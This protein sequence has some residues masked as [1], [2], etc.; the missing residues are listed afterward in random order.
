M[1]F[2]NKENA[3]NFLGGLIDAD[4]SPSLHHTCAI[5]TK[6]WWLAQDLTVLFMYLNINYGIE[7]TYNKTYDRYYYRLHIYASSLKELFYKDVIRCP[8]K[9]DILEKRITKVVK[10]QRSETPNKML[11]ITELN[12]GELVDIEVNTQNH[13]YWINGMITHNTI[14][15]GIVYGLSAYSLAMQLGYPMKTQAEQLDSINKAQMYINNWFALYGEANEWLYYIEKFA[16]KYGFVESVYG[17]RRYLP[18]VFSSDKKTKESAL[19]QARNMPIQSTAGDIN[20]IA[21]I[22]FQK[23]LDDIKSKAMP[24]GVVH[25]SI[26]VDAPEEEVE[27]VSSLLIEC[28]TVD[29]PKIEIEIKADLDILDR[30]EKVA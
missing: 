9:K 20:N 28:M 25:D 3:W 19:R 13:L 26:L 12:E 22:R 24:V 30:W 8:W 29:I 7:R 10:R 15:F 1:V 11:S 4:G 6:Y 5:T 23:R 16:L 27:M 18:K 21:L 14:N 2:Y 17:R